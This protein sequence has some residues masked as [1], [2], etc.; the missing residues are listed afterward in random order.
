MNSHKSCQVARGQ[1]HSYSCCG[2]FVCLGIASAPPCHIHF[3]CFWAVRFGLKLNILVTCL[4]AGAVRFAVKLNIL[5]SCLH[6]LHFIRSRRISQELVYT[7]SLFVSRDW[8]FN[9]QPNDEVS[10][11]MQVTCALHSWLYVF[12][13]S[14]MFPHICILLIYLPLSWGPCM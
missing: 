9:L 7:Q 3:I 4:L 5:G 10:P 11:T 13:V 12:L 14:C 6:C 1:F 2:A 8:P